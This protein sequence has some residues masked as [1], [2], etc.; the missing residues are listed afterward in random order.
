MPMAI[1]LQVSPDVCF[2]TLY[3]DTVPPKLAPSDRAGVGFALPL[4]SLI[5]TSI[6]FPDVITSLLL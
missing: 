6:F 5:T 3:L 1:V 4:F 2:I